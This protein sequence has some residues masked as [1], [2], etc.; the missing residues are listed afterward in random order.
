VP[1]SGTFVGEAQFDIKPANPEPGATIHCTFD[2]TEPTVNSPV[3]KSPVTVTRTGTV[4]KAIAV[5]DGLA[6]SDVSTMASPIVIKAQPP[7]VTPSGGVFTDDTSIVMTCPDAGCTMHYTLDGTTPT[8]GSSP[9]YTEPVPVH[10]SGTV[11]KV[12]AFADGKEPSAVVSSSPLT[13]QT[14]E[15]SFVANGTAWGQPPAGV[16]EFV[17]QAL[18]HVHSATPA[19]HI[20]Y[21]T[22]GEQPT[23]DSQLYT[24][25]E[26][27]AI[28]TFGQTKVMALAVAPG[29]S[30]SPVATSNVFEIVNR[31]ERPEIR[32]PSGTTH[33]ASVQIAFTSDAPKGVVHYTTDGTD[34]TVNSPVYTAPL[35]VRTI[36]AVVVK[37]M[38]A[39]PGLADSRVATASF[40]VLEQVKTP[41]F[42]IQSGTFTTSVTVHVSC[43][44]EGA[45]I[46]YTTNGL[47]PN[48]GSAEYVD[49]ITLDVGVEGKETTYV[50][51][52]IAMHPPTMGN[53]AVAMT[54]NLVVQ[55]QVRAPVITP[56][57]AGPF[58]DEVNVR[59][60]SATLGAAIHYSTDG[61]SPTPSSPM[62]D[63]NAGPVVIR[64]TGAVVKAMALAAHMAPSPVTESVAFDIEASPPSIEPDGGLFVDS[65]EVKITSPTPGAQIHYTLDGSPPDATSP[66]YEGPVSVGKTD[67]VIKAIAVLPGLDKSEIVDSASFVIQASPP[68]LTPDSGTFTEQAEVTIKT[69][70]PGAQIRCTLDGTDP[71]A[72]SPVCESPVQV[73]QT[74]TTVKAI[75]TKPGLQDSAVAASSAPLMITAAPPAITPD[76]GVFT[77][78]VSVTMSCSEPGCTIHYE[79]DL[80]TPTSASPLY[81]E[82]I[83]VD[84][85]DTVIKAVAMALGKATS[86]VASS[87]PLTI[88]SAPATFAANGTRWGH[89]HEDNVEDFVEAAWIS[90]HTTTPDAEIIFTT[91]GSLPSRNTGRVYAGPFQDARFGREVVKATV[92][93]RGM[94]PSPVSSSPIYDIIAK[95]PTPIIVP[96]HGGPFVGEVRVSISNVAEGATVYMTMDGSLPVE[97]QSEVYSEPFEISTPGT[98]VLKALMTNQGQADSNVA[99]ASFLVLERVETPTLDVTSG[100]FTDSVTV[101]MSCQTDGARIRYTT[102]GSQPTAASLEY[103]ADGI[104]L[105]LGPHGEEATYTIKAIAMNPPNMGDSFVA[106][107]GEL[108]V[109]PQVP[110]P[111]ITP[112]GAGPFLSPLR[113][114]LASSAPLA[115]FRYTTDGSTPTL[116]S[117]SYEGEIEITATGSVVKAVAF[118]PH[119]SPSPVATSP[120]FV[121]QVAAPVITPD[122]GHFEESVQATISCPTPGAIIHYTVG[123]FC[124]ACI[125]AGVCERA[126]GRACER[127][128]AQPAACSDCGH[129]LAPTADNGGSAG[130]RHRPHAPVGH[131]RR[132]YRARNDAAGA[133][134]RRYPRRPGRQ[135]RC[136]LSPVYHPSET[137]GV[138][139][140]WRHVRGRG[141]HLH[142][143]RD[144]RRRHPLHHRR[145]ATLG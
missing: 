30:P 86:P 89:V 102:D 11:V 67:E 76:R 96:D 121:L 113:V 46:R 16:E 144:P 15:P 36:G 120:A 31:A 25:G 21:T 141:S 66:V 80:S 99:T 3:C 6:E 135:R 108:V 14:S 57:S 115:I 20:Y 42:D 52:A 59:L 111:S 19:A 92:L 44:T 139:P 91:D 122:G 81:T 98:T 90:M 136:C 124:C 70:T 2:N 13:I 71:S 51:K 64:R 29:M 84:Q 140:Q 134:S 9:L 130:R 1:P 104:T 68:Q 101:H 75:A 4:I 137:P 24:P 126:S 22:D 60:T 114:K 125:C 117:S 123:A 45:R 93:G 128:P 54:G 138:H 34:P 131:L 143:E 83:T 105:G 103:S 12:V 133:E 28:S 129:S 107:S 32:P 132:A 106:R 49:G 41:T 109:R 53:S 23:L 87:Q 112:A 58:K 61:T 100:S 118:A 74:G 95:N 17:E 97:G 26:P 48:A 142:F 63:P 38:T 88:S 56:D 43:E 33:V 119:M 5:K 145:V 27:I 72:D 79:L 10:T 116:A 8:E 94:L 110:A 37:A 77:N 39:A 50:I 65:V 40:T 47:A 69:L 62:Y 127:A 82:P 7:V 73:T 35:N 18:V 55:P 78:Q 85:T